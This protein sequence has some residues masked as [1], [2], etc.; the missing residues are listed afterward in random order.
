MPPEQPTEH[1]PYDFITNPATSGK[2]IKSGLLNAPSTTK[3]IIVVAGGVVLLIVAF[4]VVSSLI[5]NA[6]TASLAPMLRVVQDQS[7]LNHLAGQDA[8]GQI[9]SQTA[10]NVAANVQLTMYS[11]QTQ[12]TTALKKSGQTISTGQAAAGQSAAIDSNLKA[13]AAVS[14][15]DPVL[16]QT[17]QQQMS[18]YETNLKLAAPKAN[19]TEVALLAADYNGALLL[20]KQIAAGIATV[21]GQ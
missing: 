7:E 12:L 8:Q 11:A 6:N 10:K 15:F 4:I 17:L 18:R 9:V 1:S 21:T 19:K 13:A 20:D 3:R 14:N 5:T 16:L 2:P